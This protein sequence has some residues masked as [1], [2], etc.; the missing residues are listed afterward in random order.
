MASTLEY[1][2]LEIQE[3]ERRIERLE[4]ALSRSGQV[5]PA[6]PKRH[7]PESVV[8][9][10]EVVLPV[11]RFEEERAKV[12]TTLK[13]DAPA[14]LEANPR[15]LDRIR[16]LWFYPECEQL[17][18]KLIIDDRGNRAGFNREIMDELLF[19]AGLARA[20]KMSQGLSKGVRSERSD[21]WED[22]RIQR[23]AF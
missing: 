1:C 16:M 5:S 12:R 2:L 23:H 7:L 22:Q 19:L 6:P 15:V 21:V 17:L 14:A 9:K 11:L 20:V 4:L 3:L 13:V 10:P 18:D 8:M